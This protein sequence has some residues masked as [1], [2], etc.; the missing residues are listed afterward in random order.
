MPIKT[1]K[2]AV[3][4]IPPEECW[5]PIQAIRRV[6]D[7]HVR[8]WMPHVTLIYP[9]RPHEEFDHVESLLREACRRIKPF[10]VRLAEFRHFQHGRGGC[11]LYLAPTPA[12]NLAELQAALESAVPDCNDV[13]RHSNGFT[14][15]LSVGQVRGSDARVAL[16]AE[17][18]ASWSPLSFM[19]RRVSLIWR[20]DRPDDVFR[21]DRTIALG[22]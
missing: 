5:E 16:A 12:R 7:R 6:H 11:T 20:N 21:V 9:F 19:A 18:A 14:P 13:S 2:T 1:P 4:L 3:V 17:L 8:R 15:H 22:K 10:E